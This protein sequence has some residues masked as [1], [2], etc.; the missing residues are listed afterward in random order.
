M[1]HHCLKAV[2]RHKNWI[3]QEM[4]THLLTAHQLQTTDILQSIPAE[5]MYK[6]TVEA[7]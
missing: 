3:A 4:A 1:F 5:M 2:E 7:F 6:N